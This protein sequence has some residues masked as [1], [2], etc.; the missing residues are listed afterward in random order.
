MADLTFL[1][2]VD[3]PGDPN[4]FYAPAKQFFTTAGSTIVDPPANGQ[5]L[6]G[7]LTQLASSGTAQ[8][9]INI[10]SR[11][12]GFAALDGAV[13][14]AAQTAGH[15]FTT[16]NDV[17]NAL[18]AKSLTP[19][20]PAVITDQTRVVIYGSAVGRLTG[21]LTML[22]GLFGD[23]GEVLA[24]RRMSFFTMAGPTA[25][26]RQAETWSLPWGDP[27][28][29]GNATEPSGG[30]ATFQP[31][32]AT[33]AT[34]KFTT[35]AVAVLGPPGADSLAGIIMA[36]SLSAT[37]AAGSLFFFEQNVDIVPSGSQ[38]SAQAAQALIPLASGD[39][40]VAAP[41]NWLAVD[42]TA[43][44]LTVSGS[45][46]Y[47]IDITG[48]TFVISVV[49]LAFILDVDVVIAD[50]EGYRRVTTSPGLAPSPGPDGTDGSPPAHGGDSDDPLGAIIDD[51]IAAGITQDD[52]DAL[53]ATV[54]T[55]DATEGIATDSSDADTDTGTDTDTDDEPA[56]AE[57]PD[58]SIPIDA[59]PT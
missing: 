40:V 13:T 19:P 55:G 20:G 34:P 44:V 58:D 32:F 24:P 56:D 36:G 18:A 9:T 5:T 42:D 3:P 25:N 35:A 37:N 29:P 43:E 51:L 16:V 30:W 41:A 46:A 52:I 6:E 54:P 59:E 1:M 50:N 39:P 23:P 38:T 48:T 26:Y 31:T 2:N 8:D 22:S 53:L 45:E 4:P 7:V 33:Q 47:A 27:L 57:E 11:P 12:S 15:R 14:V 17:Q 10:V 28:I 21:F 49:V